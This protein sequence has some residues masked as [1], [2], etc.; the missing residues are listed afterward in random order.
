MS[1]NSLGSGEEERVERGE[2]ERVERG[3]AERWRWYTTDPGELKKKHYFFLFNFI[4]CKNFSNH[5]KSNKE[6]SKV[7]IDN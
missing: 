6:N 1:S 7:L 2:E 3:E 4:D 5:R